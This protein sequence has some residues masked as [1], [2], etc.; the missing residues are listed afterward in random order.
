MCV[1]LSALIC[2]NRRFCLLSMCIYARLD[3]ERV[4]RKLTLKYCFAFILAFLLL[5]HS[6]TLYSTK[7]AHNQLPKDLDTR[8]V[9]D[10]ILYCHYYSCCCCWYP[11]K[12]IANKNRNTHKF[13]SYSTYTDF[14]LA[15]CN[16]GQNHR[17]AR[18]K[19]KEEKWFDF[20]LLCT[21]C[22]PFIYINNDRNW[23]NQS[24][25]SI[26]SINTCGSH[27]ATG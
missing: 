18:Q 10:A 6:F 7:I 19:Q 8:S 17:R 13:E 22:T 1:C 11:S 25:I 27:S 9:M 26:K 16:R 12:S 20:A 21:V 4:L 15:I 3:L 5:S 2:G 14:F 23:L 24:H